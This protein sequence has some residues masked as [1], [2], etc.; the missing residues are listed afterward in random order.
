MPWDGFGDTA[1]AGGD[2]ESESDRVTLTVVA[3]VAGCLRC[4]HPV[5]VEN[6]AGPCASYTK[7]VF[8]NSLCT[9]FSQH[10]MGSQPQEAP[11]RLLGPCSGRVSV[12]VGGQC[13]FVVCISFELSL[14]PQPAGQIEN[15]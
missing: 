14:Q 1:G 7:L 6:A 2:G 12:K 3:S 4:F 5:C 15:E 11:Q 8:S 13:C 10:A 9:A